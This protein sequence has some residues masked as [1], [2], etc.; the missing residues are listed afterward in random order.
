[1]LSF[2]SLSCGVALCSGR[3]RG[4]L[5]IL[6]PKQF[7]R[8]VL[9]DS[10][11][12]SMSVPSVTEGAAAMRVCWLR[13]TLTQSESRLSR[14]FERPS[15]S[16]LNVEAAFTQLASLHNLIQDRHTA[17]LAQKKVAAAG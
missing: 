15:A 16:S 4:S 8:L 10:L 17:Q 6:V 9:W 5:S 2:T 14:K 12:V 3:V 13:S 11:L 7:L 1:M